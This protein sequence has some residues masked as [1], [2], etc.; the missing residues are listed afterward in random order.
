LNKQTIKDIIALGEGYTTEFKRSGT[1]SL[2]REIN[3]SGGII[4][5]R[6][7][8]TGDIPLFGISDNWFTVVFNRSTGKVTPQVEKLLKVLSKEIGRSE[9]MNI[10]GFKDKKNFVKN[11]LRPA[12][13]SDLVEMTI[14]DKP[15]SRNQKYRLTDNGKIL[16]NPANK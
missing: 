16:I 7:S 4:L 1:T 15:R 14:P 13:E 10:M 9:I 12:L 3:A 6:V 2:G 11:I 5:I 8:D